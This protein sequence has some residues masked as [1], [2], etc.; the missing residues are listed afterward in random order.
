[1]LN[2]WGRSA[3]GDYILDEIMTP[4]EVQAVLDSYKIIP[5][6]MKPVSQFPAK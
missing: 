2:V 1:M 6:E 4:E 3:D 5:S